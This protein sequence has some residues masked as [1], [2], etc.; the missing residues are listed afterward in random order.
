VPGAQVVLTS[1]TARESTTTRTDP[2][3]RF[4]FLE[5]APGRF[6]ISAA[7][8]G[9]SG[10]EPGTRVTGQSLDVTAAGKEIDL[11]LVPWG[12]VSG[13]VLDEFGLP[14]QGASVQLLHTRFEAGRRRLVPA[15]APV[16][17]SDDRG[18]FRLFGVAPGQYIVT[19]SVGEVFATELPGY[20]RTFHPGVSDAAAAQ[21]VT[22]GT[23]QSLSGVDVELVRERTVLVAGTIR[24]AQGRPGMGG[25]LTLAPSRSSSA[26]AVPIGARVSRAG[27]FEFPNVP[28]GT[29]VIQAYRGQRNRSTEGEFGAL[30]VSVGE[31]DLTGLTLQT[32]LGSSITGR[33]SFAGAAGREPARPAIEIVPEPVDPDL[34]P[35]SGRAT[36][37]IGPDLTFVLTGISG[38]RRLQVP[39]TPA[40]WTLKEIRARGVD[41]TDRPLEFGTAAQSL[42]DVEVVL[43]DRL[44]LVGGR[45]S[46]RDGRA[47]P[48]ATVILFS[49]FRDRW[50]ARSR[51]MRS[52][53]VNTDGAFTVEGLAPG[54]YYA[55]AVARLPTGGSDAW[56]DPAFLESISGPSSRVTLGENDRASLNLTLLDAR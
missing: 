47:A 31:R 13:R 42:D 32:S 40:G 10:A 18:A 28:P 25:S 52:A 46:D 41:I 30:R 2:N 45:V 35:A 22:V 19:A 53:L 6:S 29:Y 8:V 34:A 43:T 33:V 11:A 3:G 23:G 9:Y 27:V 36:A 17:Q 12:S 51:F 4:E 21:F 49:P 38:Q 56:Q 20:T 24:D 26:L 7:K 55:A 50:Y 37:E 54:T 48:G 39:R 14:V 16:R 15:D 44:T 5:L 1:Q